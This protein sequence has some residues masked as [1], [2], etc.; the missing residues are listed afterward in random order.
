MERQEIFYYNR[1]RGVDLPQVRECFKKLSPGEIASLKPGDEI[2]Y[3]DEP[4]HLNGKVYGYTR[5]VVKRTPSKSEAASPILWRLTNP[6]GLKA[7]IEEH[8]EKITSP[9]SSAERRAFDRFQ[10]A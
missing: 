1:W 4:Y 7:L 6:Q 10:R 5:A 2:W 8:G 3:D 9:I